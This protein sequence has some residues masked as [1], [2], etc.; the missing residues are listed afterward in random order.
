VIRPYRHILTSAKNIKIVTK[1]LPA[2]ALQD[3]P[4]D[5]NK[6]AFACIFMPISPYT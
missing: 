1:V 4:D 3:Q 2:P 6:A 5:A